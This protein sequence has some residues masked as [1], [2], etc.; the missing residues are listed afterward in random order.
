MNTDVISWLLVAVLVVVLIAIFARF[1][2]AKTQQISDRLYVARCMIVNFY[3]VRTSAGV[4]LFDTGTGAA[5]ARSELQKLGIGADEVTYVFLTHSDY[6]HAGGLDAFA[7]ASRYLSSA[8][9]QM[10]DGSTARQ[11][12][13][14]NKRIK[15][16]YLMQDGETVTLGDTT[17]QAVLCP[18]H[19][20]GSTTYIVDGRLLF[21]GDLLR[22]SRG[23]AYLP[24]FRMMNM[25][26]RQ[27][28][29]SIAAMRPRLEQAEYIMSG[30]T[31]YR[32]QSR[33]GS[34]GGGG[35]GG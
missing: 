11:L 21:S 35:G 27:D 20:P 7:N 22:L 8:E 33:Q 3:A 32:Q 34:L 24:F 4:V 29:A 31:G 1:R 19:T 28:I 10:I 25:N 26:H 30:H 2:P 6:D 12:F 5:A 14:H 23:G 13:R 9:K 16:D 18:G 15:V 17:I